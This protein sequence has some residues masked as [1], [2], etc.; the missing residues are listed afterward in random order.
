MRILVTTAV[1]ILTRAGRAL[2]EPSNEVRDDRTTNLSRL[3][4]I[5]NQRIDLFGVWLSVCEKMNGGETSKS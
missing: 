4:M 5:G 2:L 3:I 1:V